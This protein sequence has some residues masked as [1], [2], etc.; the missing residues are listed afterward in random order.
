MIFKKIR[1]RDA[2]IEI[3]TEELPAQSLRKLSTAFAEMME[4]GLTEAGLRFVKIKSLVTPRR[5]ALLITQLDNKQSNRLVEKRGPALTAAFD[6]DKK[7]TKACEAFARSC[8][9]TVEKLERLETD[10]GAWVIY[11]TTEKGKWIQ[12]LLPAITQQALDQLPIPKVMRWGVGEIGFIRPVHSVIMLYGRHIVPCKIFEIAANRFT[13]GHRFHHPHAIKINRAEEYEAKLLKAKVMADI[14]KREQNIQ[15]QIETL[16]KQKMGKVIIPEG[17]LEEVAGLVEWPVG[18]VGSFDERFLKL[19]REVL[20]SVMQKHQKCF[21]VEPESAPGKKLLPYFITVSNIMSRQPAQVVQGNQRVMRARLADAE[22]FYELDIKMPLA[23]R[24]DLLK[25]ILFQKELGSLYDKTQRIVELSKVLVEK[26]QA[27]AELATRAAGLCKTDLLTQMVNEFPELQGV[28]GSYYADHDGEPNAVGVALNEQ[29]MPRFAKDQLPKTAVG[30][31]LA[32][33]DRIDTL[34]GIFGIGKAPT[35][36]KDPFALRRATLGV[37]RLAIEK[38]LDIDMFALVEKAKELYGD[39]LT[40]KKVIGDVLQFIQ[41]RH[42]HLSLR[43]GFSADTFAA[44]LA[45]DPV[46]LFDF[47][48]R[49]AAVQ[50]FQKLPEAKS[51]TVANKRVTNL[52]SKQAGDVTNKEINVNLLHEIAEKELFEAIS[53][54]MV[55][56]KRLLHIQDYAELLKELSHLQAPV[57]KFFG[58]VMVMVEDELLRNNRVSLLVLLRGLFLQVADISLLQ[59]Q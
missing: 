56:T 21:A 13:L 47:Q 2:L 36:D 31:V 9:I 5:L 59:D 26:I 42:R 46:R 30:Q 34:V 35:G 49:L 23:N 53:R 52:L 15:L 57:D 4:K 11:R 27:N 3:F 12:E 10:K 45:C 29:Y 17:L 58:E 19:P 44:V 39:R 54:K 18:L 24:V 7:P 51:L 41:E 33:A 25:N 8:G 1:R 6:Q 16:A 55:S 14:D 43:E 32:I 40:N 50:E 28:M 22:F 48:K 38:R 37:L 20:I